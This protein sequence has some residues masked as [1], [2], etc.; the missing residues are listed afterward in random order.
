LQYPRVIEEPKNSSGG[1]RLAL[2]HSRHWPVDVFRADFPATV[3]F[4]TRRV[5]NPAALSKKL[6]DQSF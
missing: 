4:A 1:S 5:F 6:E 3:S 2:P